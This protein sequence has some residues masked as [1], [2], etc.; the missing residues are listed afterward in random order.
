MKTKKQLI[1]DNNIMLQ[2]ICEKLGITTE[3]FQNKSIGGGGVSD[4]TGDDGN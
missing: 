4:P 2:A 3:D 1:A